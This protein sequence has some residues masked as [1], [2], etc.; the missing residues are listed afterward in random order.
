MRQHPRA[1]ALRSERGIALIVV[2]LLLGLLLTIVAEFAQAMRLEAVTA[3]NFRSGVSETWLAEAAYQRALAEIRQLVA[4]VL[5]LEP[6]CEG[7]EVLVGADDAHRLLLCERWSSHETFVGPH[8]QQ[9]HLQAF[10]ARAPAFLAG[11]PE[12]S[13]WT[14]G[15]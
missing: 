3:T 9:P 11:P 10:I 2:L 4:E 12:I 5:R 13:F 7:I 14:A 1:G 15:N 8:M 6:E